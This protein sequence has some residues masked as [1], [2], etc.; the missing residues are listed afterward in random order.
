[1][2]IFQILGGFCHWNA[3]NTVKNLA[4]TVGRYAP[5]IVFVE[6]PDYVFE[7]WGYDDSQTGDARFIEPVPP[8]GY[9]YE[10]EPSDR[11]IWDEL[12]AAYREGV[13]EA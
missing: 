1:M 9:L 12:A 6:A 5:D 13:G 8:E 2:K 3:T 4:G 10:P 7:G 11:T